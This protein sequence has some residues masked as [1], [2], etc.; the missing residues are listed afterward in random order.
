VLYRGKSAY[1]FAG[2][3]K[4]SRDGRPEADG[5]FRSVMQTMRDLKPSEAPLAEPF[6]VRIKQAT[7]DTKLD[8]YAASVPVDKYQKEELLL[9]NGLY[10]DRKLKAGQLYKIV[11]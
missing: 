3:S 2:A 9:M 8:E 11:E 7:A 6:R 10:P 5:L 1:V 4:S